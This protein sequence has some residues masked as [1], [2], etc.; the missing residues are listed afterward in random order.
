MI[1]LSVPEAFAFDYLSILMVKQDNGLPV[2][3]ELDRQCQELQKA[4][5]NFS[6]I[7]GS[8]E[9]RRL[10]TS[11]VHVWR[12]VSMAAKDSIS[13]KAVFDINR[14]RFECKQALQ[15]RFWPQEQVVEEKD[16]HHVAP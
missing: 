2:G 1:P 4:C 7:L 9:F 14:F 16:A 15:Q 5:P 10:K 13:A 12:A 8:E 3:S 6:T 11:N